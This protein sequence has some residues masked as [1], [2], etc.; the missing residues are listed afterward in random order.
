MIQV[1]QAN[2][3][4][5]NTSN[6][7]LELKSY[8]DQIASTQNLREQLVNQIYIITS[9]Q[10]SINDNSI[11]NNLDKYLSRYND[12]IATINGAIVSTQDKVSYFDINEEKSSFKKQKFSMKLANKCEEVEKVFNDVATLNAQAINDAKMYISSHKNE[13]IDYSRNVNINNTILKQANHT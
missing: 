10:K 3:S 7:S 9:I 12:S 5:Y 6:S 13:L 4:H 11:E 1:K 8:M 2:N